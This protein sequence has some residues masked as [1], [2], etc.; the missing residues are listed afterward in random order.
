MHFGENQLS[1]RSFGISPLPT[2]HPSI[3]NHR[4]V[5][6]SSPHYR[7]FTLAMGS[8]RGFGSAR[9]HTTPSSDSLSLRLRALTPLTSRDTE[10]LAGSFFNRHAVTA[11]AAPTARGRTVSGSLHPPPG[12]L[13]TFPS[14]YCSL[15]VVEG[16]QPWRVVPPASRG[17]PRAPRYSGAQPAAPVAFRLRDCHPL[18]SAIPG[19]S[20]RRRTSAPPRGLRSSPLGPTTPAPQRPQAWHG[21]G[22]GSSAFAHHY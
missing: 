3:L 7:A 13:F 21:T 19:R 5:R 14:R 10:Q 16:I 8:S 1:P 2:A 15:S 4:W 20:A 17:I 6:A 11:R 22:L 9:C 18:R 12:V